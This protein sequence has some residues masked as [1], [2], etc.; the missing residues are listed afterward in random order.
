MPG[1]EETDKQK[2]KDFAKE[3]KEKRTKKPVKQVGKR[4]SEEPGA[5]GNILAEKEMI[6]Q[7]CASE[8]QGSSMKYPK[9]GP[10]EFV[11]YTF[12]EITD[13]FFY[14]RHKTEVINR[15]HHIIVVERKR[16]HVIKNDN[17]EIY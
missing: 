14:Y 10:Q 9:I 15:Y 3:M 11:P 17:Y 2:W 13:L 1:K 4:K 5:G 16:Q 7:R 8:T 12:E 6:V